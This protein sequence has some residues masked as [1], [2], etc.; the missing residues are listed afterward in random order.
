MYKD[1]IVFIR[2]R[3]AVGDKVTVPKK[4]TNDKTENVEAEILGKYPHVMLVSD[5]LYKWCVSW[6]DMAF[7]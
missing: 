1:D 6:V 7:I 3:Y 2:G 4:I 5:G